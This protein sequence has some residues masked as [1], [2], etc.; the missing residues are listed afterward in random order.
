MVGTI[1]VVE[2]TI[3]K[4][5]EIGI[6]IG[7]E[8][9]PEKAVGALVQGLYSNRSFFNR[10]NDPYRIISLLFVVAENADEEVAEI[11]RKE[12]IVPLL[13][14]LMLTF[15]DQ[16]YVSTCMYAH[17]FVCTYVRM[18]ICMYAMESCSAIIDSQV[19]HAM[20]LCREGDHPIS[21]FA[22]LT[23]LSSLPSA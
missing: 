1:T 19:S 16:G 18:P 21:T 4:G 5:K 14:I 8:V 23:A 9:R 11:E 15:G 20:H 10:L 6:G 2:A 7:A 22:L 13:E 3:E 17:M 12:E